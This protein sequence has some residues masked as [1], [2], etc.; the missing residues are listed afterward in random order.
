MGLVGR[1]EGTERVLSGEIADLVC[2][3]L[4]LM[5]HTSLSSLLGSFFF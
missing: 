4:H 5:F 2:N 1:R 3:I